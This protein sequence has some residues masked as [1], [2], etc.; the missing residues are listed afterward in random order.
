MQS[1]DYRRDFTEPM[2]A[3]MLRRPS[4]SPVVTIL[5]N[6]RGDR[7]HSKGRTGGTLSLPTLD[8]DDP[9]RRMWLVLMS[10]KEV[11][12]FLTHHR[13]AMCCERSCL[14]LDFIFT[15]PYRVSHAPPGQDRLVYRKVVTLWVPVWTVSLLA[16]TTSV[17]IA[18]A[19]RRRCSN[20]RPDA[21]RSGEPEGA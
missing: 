11:T 18:L 9:H 4:R 15:M 19:V 17:P 10:S 21:V 1:L 12:W 5:D 3:A 6:H 2:S 20:R 7:A 13:V 16:I 14:Y 8:D